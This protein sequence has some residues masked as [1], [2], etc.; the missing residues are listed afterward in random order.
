MTIQPEEYP[1]PSDV[2]NDDRT[3]LVCEF[4]DNNAAMGKLIPIGQRPDNNHTLWCHDGRCMGWLTT[5][6]G[7]SF[8]NLSHET[9]K[10]TLTIGN[11]PQI[12]LAASKETMENIWAF[13]G[14]FKYFT[15]TSGTDS[16]PISNEGDGMHSDATD[17][18]AP[19][20]TSEIKVK[21][22]SD[23]SYKPPST[24]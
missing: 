6:Y 12:G 4:G 11:R 20:M 23:G 21:T 3:C 9:P 14:K 22:N 19:A 16:F 17:P 8:D 18:V 24:F 15:A 5:K 13:A 10:S 1:N 7:P 2:A